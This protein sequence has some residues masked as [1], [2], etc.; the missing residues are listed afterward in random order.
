MAEASFWNNQETAQQTV[1]QLKKL[2]ASIDPVE[3]ASA[4]CDDQRANI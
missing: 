4:L 3:A 1:A 2:N